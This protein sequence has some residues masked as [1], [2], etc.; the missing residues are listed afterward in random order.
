[1]NKDVV[2]IMYTVNRYFFFVVF[3]VVICVLLCLAFLYYKLF[4]DYA[5][6]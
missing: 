2:L 5:P 3:H 6:E 4:K 1:M